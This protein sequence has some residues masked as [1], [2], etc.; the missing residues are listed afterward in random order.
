M[1]SQRVPPPAAQ[2][3]GECRSDDRLA[4]STAPRAR[5]SAPNCTRSS[6]EASDGAKPASGVADS[7]RVPTFLRRETRPSC[8]S[9]AAPRARCG[10][11]C[12]SARTAPARSAA[13]SRR[14]SG[15]RRCAS[16]RWRA[17]SVKCGL[18]RC[19]RRWT[20][21]AC[22]VNPQIAHMFEHIILHM[23][24]HI[25]RPLLVHHTS[26]EASMSSPSLPMASTVVDSIL[27]RDAFGT[28]RDARDLLRPRA[29]PA[30]HRRRGGA[31]QGRGAL[32][33]DPG[34]KRPR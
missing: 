14:G 20:F 32:R 2:F 27:F 15:R 16:V 26:T 31:G 1:R 21:M 18:L 23:F 5:A 28:P 4:R 8:C 22:R 7:T 17:M 10:G 29:D 9:S 19:W 13:A 24:E 12:R 25:D 33:R 11:W 3:L 6:T 30:L 34:R